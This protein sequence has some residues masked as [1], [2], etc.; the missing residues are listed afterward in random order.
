MG[1]HKETLEF[2]G[3]IKDV[4]DSYDFALTIRQIFYQLVAKQIIPNL[5]GKYKKVSRDCVTGRDLGLLP[6]DKFTDRT[7]VFDKLSSWLDLK[8]F[9]DTVKN[10]YLKDKWR[11]QLKY[12]EIW[13]EKD[14]LRAVINIITHRYDVGLQ[15]ARG[16]YPRTGIYETSLRY[17]AQSDKECFLYYVGDYDPSGL[18]IY[19]SIKKRLIKYGV[20]VEIPD[21]IALTE[22]QIEKYRLPSDRAK[23]TDKN[24]DKFVEKT[25][26]DRVVELDSLPPDILRKI[27]ED[28]IMKNIDY[29]LL[30]L[31]QEKERDEGTRLD[32]FIEKGI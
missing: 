13:T 26:S 15:I 8:D 32:K 9:M 3:Q 6:E 23:K 16:Q 18:A 30:G 20:N 4:L 28:C 5:E 10:A 22:D 1:I 14:A 27:I 21:R 31:V 29:E 11:N 17:K 12:I 24:Y 25:G 19:E 7:R 2:I